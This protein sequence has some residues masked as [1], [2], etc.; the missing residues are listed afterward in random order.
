MKFTLKN[1]KQFGWDGLKGYAYNDSQDFTN[2]S[3]AYFEVT[4]SHGKVKTIKSDRVYYVLEGSGEFTI[5][6]KTILVKA[7]DMVI[8]P[9]N[10]EYDYKTT[11]DIMK[12]FLVHIPAYDPDTEVKL[13]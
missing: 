7:T 1:A 12:L 13:E 11:S 3:G 2:A 8:V 9:K 6:G 5:A 10:T 4:A